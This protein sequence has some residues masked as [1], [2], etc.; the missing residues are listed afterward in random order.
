MRS[1]AISFAMANVLFTGILAAQQ[2]TDPRA[3]AVP[4]VQLLPLQSLA[5]D[6]VH[7]RQPTASGATPQGGPVAFVPFAKIRDARFAPDGRLA[8]LLVEPAAETTGEPPARRELLAR[9]VQWDTLNKRW[10]TTDPNLKFAELGEAGVPAPTPAGANTR[11]AGRMLLASELVQ[12]TIVTD[13]APAPTKTDDAPASTTPAPVFWIVPSQQTL[14]LAVIEQ[15]KRHV[16]LPWSLL[17]LSDERGKVAF[18]IGADTAR[19]REAPHGE[20]TNDPP[21]AELRHRVYRHFGIT[22][23]SWEPLPDTRPAAK[24][25]T[26]PG[27]KP[28][29]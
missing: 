29:R 9:Q 10:I 12:S 21:N 6:T 25:T 2:P 23:P 15:D 11:P 26:E 7:H 16:P 17:R 5:N 13:P 18:R 24:P 4:D 20:N 28:D 1:E 8:A 22:P 3:P 19:L 27:T 14:A